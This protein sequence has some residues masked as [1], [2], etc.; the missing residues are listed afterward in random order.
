MRLAAKK[1]TDVYT[2]SLFTPSVELE[3]VISKVVFVFN[4]GAPQF[5][6]VLERDVGLL[7][8]QESDMKGR[9]HIAAILAERFT[10]RIKNRIEVGIL[11]VNQYLIGLAKHR[12]SPRK[13]IV[14]HELGKLC[15]G[16]E[17]HDC[18]FQFAFHPFNFFMPE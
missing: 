6:D 3:V 15:L 17:K 7:D 16:L 4:D 8:I 11:R 10:C 5:S 13:R 9:T 1:T 14:R 18:T 12:V 2:A